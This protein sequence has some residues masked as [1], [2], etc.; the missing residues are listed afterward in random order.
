M[1]G[2]GNIERGGAFLGERGGAL[3]VHN[4]GRHEADAGMTM[5]GVVP[6]EEVL[7]MCTGVLDRP[8]AR[9]E[10]GAVLQ[11]FSAPCKGAISQWGSDPPG[12]CRSSR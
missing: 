3:V 8:E 6:P 10:V 9:W 7:A 2:E 11:G 12:N 4:V 1:G 5:L